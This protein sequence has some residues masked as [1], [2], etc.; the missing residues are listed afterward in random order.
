MLYC[1]TNIFRLKASTLVPLVAV[2]SCQFVKLRPLQDTLKLL[3]PVS[4]DLQVDPR[5]CQLQVVFSAQQSRECCLFCQDWNDGTGVAH[6]APWGEKIKNLRGV[7]PPRHSCG[8]S[9]QPGA[10]KPPQPPV[11]SPPLPPL[12][13]RREGI[14]IHI[15]GS[16]ILK[17]S[18]SRARNPHL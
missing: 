15:L 10:N 18:A 9:S 17:P 7:Q 11:S 3:G 14:L 13:L 12:P 16:G 6:N 2:D 8:P 1:L 5:R 4:P